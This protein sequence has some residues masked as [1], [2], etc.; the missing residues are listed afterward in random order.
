MK[1][2]R[3]ALGI[4]AAIAILFAGCATTYTEESLGLRKTD[5]YTEGAETVGEKT[6]YSKVSAGSGQFI[7]RAFE[8]APPMIPHDVKGMLPIKIGNNA[9]LSCHT[10][11]V[12]AAVNATPF[13]A[14]HMTNYRPDTSIASDGQIVKD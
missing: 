12:A 10:P 7:N 9:C 11:E 5:L 8:N 13:P 1:K 2:L 6:N 14:S 3:I 4:V